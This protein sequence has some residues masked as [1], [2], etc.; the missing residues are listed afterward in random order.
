[1]LVSDV[2]MLNHFV[3][4]AITW[5]GQMVKVPV[6][7]CTCYLIFIIDYLVLFLL[8]QFINHAIYNA[9]ISLGRPKG[10]VFCATFYDVNQIPV[11]LSPRIVCIMKQKVCLF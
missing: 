2:Y 3:K 4:Y 6:P 10:P 8:A 9:N 1:M 5:S 11:H 7:L